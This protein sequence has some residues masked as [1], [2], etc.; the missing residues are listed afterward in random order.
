MAVPSSLK[1]AEDVGI[2]WEVTGRGGGNF[3]MALPRDFI[4]EKGDA[5]VLPGL[6]PM[7]LAVAETVLSDPRSPWK[8][9]LLKSPVNIQEI[10]F[11]QV[12]I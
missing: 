6:A 3:E 9:A 12:E 7:T 11:V 2:F 4:L 10:K 1:D 5:V 8:T